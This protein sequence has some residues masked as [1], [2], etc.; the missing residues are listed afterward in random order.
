MTKQ[1][2]SQTVG[3]FF[4]YGLTPEGYGHKGIAGNVLVTPATVG[5][6]IRIEG[7]VLDGKG[8]PVNDAL[9]EIWQA[10]AV[11]RYRHTADRRDAVALDPSFAGFGRTLTDEAGAFRFDTIKPG[12]VPGRGNALPAPHI[13]LIV[14]A[15][16]MPNH[17]YSRIY[18]S[19]EAQANGD[20]EVLAA[21]DAARRGTLIAERRDEPGGPVYRFDIRLQGDGETVFF[22]A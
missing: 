1:T 13:G 12:R 22:D 5:E 19:D 9:L 15:R 7:R 8:A 2:P 11:G 20:D 6:R 3:P 17:V 21:V 18:F 16:G 4:A 10:N 14:L